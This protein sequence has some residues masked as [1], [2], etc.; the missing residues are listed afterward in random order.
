MH[1]KAGG[2]ARKFQRLEDDLNVLNGTGAATLNEVTVKGP[3]SILEA[4]SGFFGHHPRMSSEAE[5]CGNAITVTAEFDVQ[6][7]RTGSKY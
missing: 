4:E 3:E 6:S 7:N 1:T 2:D 5:S